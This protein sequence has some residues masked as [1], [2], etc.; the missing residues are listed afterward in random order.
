[1]NWELII[2]GALATLAALPAVLIVFEK[3][4]VRMAFLLL[5]TLLGV[6]GLY[7]ALG[8]DFLGLTQ[9]FVY[10]GGITVLLLFGIMMTNNDP[11]F[12]RHAAKSPSKL[13]GLILGLVLFGGLFTA[14]M[15]TRWVQVESEAE[16]T[17][18]AI[19]TFLLSDYILPFEMVSVLLLAVLVGAAYVA[20]RPSGGEGKK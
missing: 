8:A 5:T 14:I 4:I 17:A 16:P 13:P 19:G 18:Q 20:R 15:E 6:A 11:I 9:I 7:L 12:V 1:M 3:N 10:I 2:F